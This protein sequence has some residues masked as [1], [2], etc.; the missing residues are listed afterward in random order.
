MALEM[1]RMALHFL[2]ITHDPYLEG[3]HP[4]RGLLHSIGGW[5][6]PVWAGDS[7]TYTYAITE[8]DYLQMLWSPFYTIL[9]PSW[10]GGSPERSPG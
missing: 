7:P 1:C 9:A 10:A 2:N 8:P 4:W 5:R 6:R 3:R